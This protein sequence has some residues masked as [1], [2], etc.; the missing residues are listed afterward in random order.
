[1]F[2]LIL[3]ENLDSLSSLVLEILCFENAHTNK[4]KARVPK[5]G[6]TSERFSAKVKL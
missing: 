3:T 1:M 2:M 6:V 5:A 4:E